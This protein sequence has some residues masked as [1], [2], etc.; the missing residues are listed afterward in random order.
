MAIQSQRCG[1][2]SGNVAI[3]LLDG[4][5][6][7]HTA[8]L[9]LDRSY[10]FGELQSSAAAV[11]HYLISQGGRKGDRAVL[12]SENSFFWI[13]AYL[14]TLLAGMVSVPVAPNTAPEDLDHM[15]RLTEPR[16]TFLQSKIAVANAKQFSRTAIIT[17]APRGASGLAISFDDVRRHALDPLGEMPQVSGGDLAAIIFTS[18]S[19]G[20]PRGVKISHGNIIANTESIIQYLKLS[21]TDRIMAVLPLYYC[22]G[23]SLLHTHLRVGGSVVLDLRFMYPDT[24][25]KRMVETECTGFAGVPSHYQI[26]LRR[27]SLS[28]MSFPSLRYVQQA[29]GH[30]A[31]VFV[32]EL[33]AALPGTQIFLMY[34]QTEAT[35]RLSYL[36]PELVG[37]KSASIGKAIPGVRLR[38]VT[39]EGT[40]ARP[41]ETGEIIAE[42]DNISLGYWRDPAETETT[43]RD[44]KL[45]TGDLATVDEDGFLYL[46]DRAK[47]FVKCGGERVSCQAVE[48]QLLEF[49]ALLEAAVI[50]IPD[51]VLGEAIK[52]FVVP[53][54]SG[55][56]DLDNRLRQFCKQHLPPRLNPKI[57]VVLNSLPKNSA[58]KVLKAALRKL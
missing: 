2:H 19:T 51:E 46:V 14:G 27:S 20:K 42:G 49:D 26:L 9:S 36:P 32:R 48:E 55:T 54:E 4:K 3:Y 23:A 41:N 38:V 12:A 22:F 28:R 37:L 58:G 33:Q 43:F 24:V 6:P 35:A 21:Q 47:D 30:L 57:I 1:F 7:S 16:F 13:S 53:R 39:S 29:G 56:P 15:V 40:D 52:L 8:L 34:G 50:G 44:G 25:L 5:E 11:A 17:D 45:H 18:G 31:P 10:T